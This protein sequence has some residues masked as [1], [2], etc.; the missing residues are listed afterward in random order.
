M[1]QSNLA[2]VEEREAE[3]TSRSPSNLHNFMIYD[4]GI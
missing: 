3:A 4:I 2:G 1:E